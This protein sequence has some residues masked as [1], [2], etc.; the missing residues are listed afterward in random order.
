MGVNVAAGSVTHAAVAEGVGMEYVPVERALGLEPP[1]SA[2][3]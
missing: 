3:H 2:N 1:E